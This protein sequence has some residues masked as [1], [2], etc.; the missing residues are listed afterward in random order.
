MSILAFLY[1]KEQNTY[2]TGTLHVPFVEDWVKASKLIKVRVID[3]KTDSGTTKNIIQ[4]LSLPHKWN[5]M[6]NNMNS[7]ILIKTLFSK[8]IVFLRGENAWTSKLCLEQN[9]FKSR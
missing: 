2:D 7:I 1:E 5:I 9:S 8:I 3:G 6:L 4:K